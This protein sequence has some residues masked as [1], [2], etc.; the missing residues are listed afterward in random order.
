[1]S[2]PT[3]TQTI[4]ILRIFDVAKAREFYLD[5]LGFTLDWE[6]RFEPELP[7]YM[8]VSR[9]GLALH[10]SEHHGD[11]CPGGAVFVEMQ[12]IE[13]LHRELIDKHY[14]YNRPGLE[15]APWNAWCMEVVDPFGNRLRFNE[16][17]A[18]EKK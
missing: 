6:H 8:Q 15:R 13:E 1:M 4:P 5:F 7:V 11:C 16:R 2:L 18:E 12:G 17:V 14:G 10:L 3:F 9:G